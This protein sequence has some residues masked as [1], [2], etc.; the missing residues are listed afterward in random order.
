MH[1]DALRKEKETETRGT[2]RFSGIRQ[3][4]DTSTDAAP[5]RPPTI[6]PRDEMKCRCPPLHRQKKKGALFIIPRRRRAER[7]VRRQAAPSV[8][9]RLSP[10][11]DFSGTRIPGARGGC[12]TTVPWRRCCSAGSTRRWGGLISSSGLDWRRECVF[13]LSVTFRLSPAST[14][15]GASDVSLLRRRTRRAPRATSDLGET[16]RSERGA[17]EAGCAPRARN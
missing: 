12:P 6:F 14:L 8:V 3:R 13:P 4:G 10:G 7:L 11:A 5:R 2:G 1:P 17:R 16:R 9:R 15:G